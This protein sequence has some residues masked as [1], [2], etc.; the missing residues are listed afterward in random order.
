MKFVATINTP[1]YLP[2]ADEPT[3]FDT[4]SEAWAY[5]EQERQDEESEAAEGDAFLPTEC[6]LQLRRIAEDA[7]MGLVTPEW[8]I[9]DTPGYEGDNDLGVAYS[10]TL[11]EGE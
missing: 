8:V 10:V 1:G 6:L 2:D 11:V 7:R 9:G 5:L 4:A 3:V